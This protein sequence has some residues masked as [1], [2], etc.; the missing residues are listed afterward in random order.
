MK[1]FRKKIKIRL[2]WRNSKSTTEE[3]K[4]VFDS[5]VQ[6][7]EKAPE[8][9]V[10]MESEGVDDSLIEGSTVIESYSLNAPY[11]YAKILKD[12]KGGNITYYLEEPKLEDSDIANLKRLKSLLNEVLD[13]KPS[14]LKSKTLAAEYL[15]GKTS[16]ILENYGFNLDMST[17]NKL[18]YYIIRDN[19]GLGKIDAFSYDPL[20]E[21]ISCDGIDV[22][23]YV[24]HRRYESIP[25]NIRFS[26][27]NELDAFA[28][29]LAYLCGSHVSIAQPMLDSSMPDGSRINLTYGS[30]I[31][32]RGSTFTIRK[33]KADPF[34]VTDIV[35]FNTFSKEM[36]AYF[37][38]AVENRV[39]ILV[40][41]GIAAGKTT[42]LNCL[43]M[44]IK[45]DLKVV[46]I[47]DT[48]ELNLPHENWIPAATRT[49]FGV[50]T[51]IAEITLFDLLKAS[52]RQR[53]DYII[54]GEIRGAEAY[55][56]FQAVS[57]GHLGMS[58][59][60]A[61]SVESTVY[62]LESAPMNIPRTLIAGIDL[63]LVMKRVEHK[64]SPARR[65]VAT[66]EIVG[67]DPRSGEILT[68]EIFKWNSSKDTFDYT[69]RSYIL[70]KIAEK[71]GI[72][73]DEV[74]KELQRRIQVIDWMA[75]ND[76]RNYKDVSKTIRSYYK[77]PK[78]F[79][80]EVMRNE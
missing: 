70:E 35:N 40:A 44:F 65:T 36:A 56:L 24:W 17:A 55:T 25:T 47:E 39:S 69:G 66:S 29:R 67:L 51:G 63:F 18:L 37:W 20:I 31:T 7:E 10:M 16:E 62:R 80:K 45:P 23:I 43:S 72:D 76:I 48:R 9:L 4:P 13:L 28:L 54:V 15:L 52:L 8:N 60:H 33:F 50:T 46:S 12:V 27:A 57:T 6:E 11:A 42:L 30:E 41:G 19:L 5:D 49:H 34:T 38:Y 79:L 59:I 2:K 75:K 77:N 53:P 58:T 22:P 68:N 73:I 26:S 1:R 78:S 3:K 71:K 21:D 14:E 61:E 74:S 32:R 64:G